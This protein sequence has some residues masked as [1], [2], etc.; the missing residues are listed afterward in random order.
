M[1][2]D[3]ASMKSEEIDKSKQESADPATSEQPSD[4]LLSG[5]SQ[6]Q[7]SALEERFGHIADVD[8]MNDVERARLFGD[9][10][11]QL[12]GELDSLAEK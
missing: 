4:S 2:S 8:N 1:G 3:E 11:S 7:I 6:K 5:L 10:L 9:V 12:R